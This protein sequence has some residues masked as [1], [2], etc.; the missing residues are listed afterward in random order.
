VGRFFG[1]VGP[2]SSTAELNRI[3]AEHPVFRVER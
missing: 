1:A 2:D 3:A